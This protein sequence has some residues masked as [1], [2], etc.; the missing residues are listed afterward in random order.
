M[1]EA[2]DNS[3]T[4]SDD[5]AKSD[6]LS[7]GPARRRA[8]S[9]EFQKQVEEDYNAE[10]EQAEKE[11]YEDGRADQRRDDAALTRKAAA[12][13]YF[14]NPKTY[15]KTGLP[16]SAPEPLAI[17]P[18]VSGNATKKWITN[19]AKD[20]KARGEKPIRITHFAQAFEKRMKEAAKNNSALRPVG[21]RHI[22]N[23]L[24]VWDLWPIEKIR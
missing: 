3:N 16:T 12:G 24:P 17:T 2:K 7:P 13:L 6:H 4:S 15:P 21:W 19:E 20:M 5:S 11:A 8:L 9:A 10:K 22:K 14:F 18:E 23:M 1:A